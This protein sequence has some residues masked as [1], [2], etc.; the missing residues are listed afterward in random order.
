MSQS[1]DDFEAIVVD[2]AGDDPVRIPSDD[3]FRLVRLDHRVP[4]ASALN[5]GIEAATGR[6]LAFLD[7]DDFWAPDRLAHA[8]EGLQRAP[9]TVCWR[10]N[11]STGRNKWKRVLEGN[12]HEV[13]CDGAIPLVGQ[14]STRRD[15][16]PSFDGH[17]WRCADVEWW[18]R[19]SRRLE[20]STVPQVG[21]YFR[22]HPGQHGDELRSLRVQSRT[23]IYEKH[24]DYFEQRPTIAARFLRRTAL[25]A[26]RGGM[27]GV[28]RP[29]FIE[30]LR[31]RPTIGALVRLA[32][33]PLFFS[34]TE[35]AGF[36]PHGGQDRALARRHFR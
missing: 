22:R 35:G 28:A 25:V 13:I 4:H 26:Q 20:V 36:T 3:R 10:A 23:Y 34:P 16:M 7:D 2:V 19:A 14:V 11:P 1:V 12:V 29:L 33:P 32:A 24:R 30:S 17:L 9:I 15:L 27:N 5:A 21:L 6:Y 8:L 18:I 31:R